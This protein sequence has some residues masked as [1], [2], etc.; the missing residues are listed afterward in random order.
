MRYT[1]GCGPLCLHAELARLLP[2]Q[3]AERETMLDAIRALD[4]KNTARHMRERF[5]TIEL[6]TD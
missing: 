6:V 5:A 2:A 1:A 3:T 4:P